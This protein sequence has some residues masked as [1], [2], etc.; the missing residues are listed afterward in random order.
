MS[1]LFGAAINLT[2]MST[3]I[4]FLAAFNFITIGLLI[5]SLANSENT[6]LLTSLLIILPMFFLSN[7]FF[8]VEIM[9]SLIK[10]IGNNLPLTLAIRSLESLLTYSSAIN[11]KSIVLL[12]I[13]PIILAIFTYFL[14]KKRPTTQ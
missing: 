6:A 13:Y 1:L 8:P 3:L 4:F 11:Y 5:G 2:S 10:T 14:I 12:V 9:P 7:L